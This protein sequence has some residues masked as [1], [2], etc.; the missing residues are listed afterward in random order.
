VAQRDE[1]EGLLRSAALQNARS[2]LTARQRAEQETERAKEE[3]RESAERLQL[4]LSA[5]RLGDWSWN[6]SDDTVVLGPRAAELYGVP[7]GEPY[8]RTGMRGLLHEEDA[9]RA[10]DTLTRAL[11]ER[12]GYN[13][14][15]RVNHPTHGQR[16]IAVTGVATHAADGTMTGMIGVVQDIHERKKA[17]DALRESAERL[18]LALAAGQL[19]D[20]SWEAAADRVVL[21]AK[22]A[23]IF[24]L[25]PDQPV[26][27]ARIRAALHP[28]DV[29][30][31]REAVDRALAEHAI[32]QTEYRIM[33]PTRGERWVAAR[34]LGAYAPDGTNLGMSGVFQDITERKKAEDALKET[35][36]RLQMAVEAGQMGDWEWNIPA[37]KVIW[38]PGLEAIHGLPP[39][40][41]GG[42]FE[43]FK[44]DIHPQ[45]LARVLETI[46]RS[47]DERSDYR[48]E[49]RII[50]PDASLTWIEARGKLLLD[51]HGTPERMAGICM[52]I[53]PR[54]HA[55]EKLQDESRILELL[56]RTGSVLAATLDLQALVQAVTDAATQLSGA[57]FGA[58]FYN[59]TDD[60]G[61]SFLLY[62]L[63]GAPREAFAIFGQPRATALFGPTF[64]GEAPIRSDDVRKDPRYGKWAPHHGMPPG[65]LPVCSYLGVPVIARSGEVIGGLF[66]GHPE[67]GV[68]TERTERIMVGIAAQAA[69]AI[70]NARLYEA[71]QK[72]AEERKQ[73]LENEQAARADA[74]RANAMKDEFLATLSHELRTPLNSILGWSQVLKMGSSSAADVQRGLDAIERNARVQA[75]LIEDLLDMSRITSG[76]VR[77]EIQ[78]VEPIPI[79][80]AA[81]ETVRPA[82][83]AKHIRIEKLFDS[84]AAPI[85]GDPS[86]LQQVIWNLLSNAIKFTPKEG[87]VQVVLER[88]NSHIEISVA[89]TGIGIKPEFLPYVF[90]RFRQADAS[91]TRT[92]G[93]L[94]LGL[95]IV[96]HLV[97]LHGGTVRVKSAGEGQGTTFA[98]HLPL[99]VVHRN[100]ESGERVHPKTPQS[101]A[102]FKH[103]DLAGIK[104]LVVDDE[105]DARELVKHV[106]AECDAEVLTAETAD[107]ALAIIERDR[108]HVLVSDIGMPV[109]DGYELLKRVRALGPARGGNLPAVALTAFARSEDRTRALR[110]GFLVHVSKPVEPAELVATVASVSGRT[111]K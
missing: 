60:K 76:K 68:F 49:Y 41:F 39:G 67:P 29:E 57:K 47:V 13:I 58:F 17:E 79:I 61:D 77:L 11:A 7:P 27:R 83:E 5:G 101:A 1:E 18:Q 28:D 31:A 104:V 78:P 8:T 44:R 36:G 92:F 90:D 87:K 106:L 19:G 103:S 2:I 38:S 33:H 12:T 43:D 89:D 99:T 3:L 93:G 15:Y 69:V 73:L 71:A 97:E 88:V 45:D 102:D 85:Y 105:A 6:I 30:H 55:E 96:K 10:R 21:G 14:E 46:Q 108:P 34:G 62:T 54:K 4:A 59:T 37:G 63:S 72:A 52:D 70:D 75:Q 23:D 109:V 95:A 50:K 74:E 22:A 16:W 53:T 65:H 100:S 9:V 56:N 111:G 24:G 64:K 26:T 91:T 81:I 42:G 84:A 32:Y 107:D 80:E 48:V 40:G 98:V 110:A 86:R 20:W 25:P 35:Q 66:F 94:G 82:A 51:A